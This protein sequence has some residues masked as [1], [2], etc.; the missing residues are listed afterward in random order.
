MSSLFRK[1]T[2]PW[3]LILIFLL[4]CRLVAMYFIPLNDSTEARYAEIARK[5]LETG[6]WVTL[7]HDYGLPFW[8]KPPLSSWLSAL[9]MN[10]FGVNAFAARLPSLIFSLGIL[11]LIANF[12]KKHT[13]A[14]IAQSCMLI[15]AS[16]LF[17]F[18][19]AGAVMTDA[20]LLFCTTLACIAFWEAF[21]HENI[22]WGY[23][24][25]FSL[26][27]G[28][29]AKGPLI[30]VLTSLPILCWLILDCFVNVAARENYPGNPVYKQMQRLGKNLP[31]MTG[32]LLLLAIALPWYLA[33]EYRTPGF[34]NYFI[35]GE[36]FGRFLIPG[37]TG[38]KYGFAHHQPLGMIWIYFILGFLPWSIAAFYHL[39]SRQKKISPVRQV[40]FSQNGM[41]AWFL[42]W[43]LMPLLFFSLARNIIYTYSFTSLPP[44][45]VLMALFSVSQR[46]KNFLLLAASSGLLSLV[47]TG[48]SLFLPD[49][50]NNTQ[51][52]VIA[53]WDHLP[54]K[55]KDTILYWSNSK[56]YS[57]EFYSKG[58][59]TYVASPDEF[60][61]H[62]KA[63]GIYY[64]VINPRELQNLSG[65]AVMQTLYQDRKKVLL[66]FHSNQD[67][68]FQ[69]KS[70]HL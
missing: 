48:M 57:A 11:A 18:I 9:S 55:R 45:A 23:A 53:V 1:L 47:I 49:K 17:F 63:P 36:H 68:N 14:E 51:K 56:S 39:F 60:Q 16:S 8:A 67:Q 50:I 25:F 69:G 30:L 66:S 37:W 42:L 59:V 35:L 58:R 28:L 22:G 13:S 15:L 26:G 65:L 3:S 12:L 19:D 46:K 31:W 27:L 6:D 4:A 41:H 61:K 2:T 52:P 29:L 70:A 33:A 43:M 24:F 32:S 10:F 40:L 20:G 5:M 64:I 54:K 44:S 21:V 7:W 38:D 34:L 62:T